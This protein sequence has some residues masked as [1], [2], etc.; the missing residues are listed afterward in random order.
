MRAFIIALGFIMALGGT[1]PGPAAAQDTDIRGVISS[2]IDAFKADDFNT[3]FSFAAPTIQNIFRTPENFGRMVS[4]GY[5]MVWRPADVE[6][7]ELR[8][9]NGAIFQD[10]RITDAEGRVHLLEYRMTEMAT[11]WKISGVRLLEAAGVAA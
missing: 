10:L 2:Q 1:V 6:Y 7:L 3:A 4:Q 5:P 8:Q 11:G 9:E